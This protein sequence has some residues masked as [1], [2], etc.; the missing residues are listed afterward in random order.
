MG[1]CWRSS[2]CNVCKCVGNG[3]D[4]WSGEVVGDK[5]NARAIKCCDIVGEVKIT[6]RNKSSF[7]RTFRERLRI[8][9]EFN[10]AIR[11]SQSDWN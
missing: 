5:T 2:V 8:L 6:D 11:R 7:V 4:G 10:C 9:C 1:H 3:S